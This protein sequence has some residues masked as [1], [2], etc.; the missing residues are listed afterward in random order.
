MWSAEYENLLYMRRWTDRGRSQ[1]CCVFNLG[2]KERNCRPAFPS[3]KWVS[4]IDSADNKWGGKGSKL[5]DRTD[6]DTEMI[7]KGMSMAMYRQL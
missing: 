5:P 2:M 1:I 7:L 3:G 6:G 4:I